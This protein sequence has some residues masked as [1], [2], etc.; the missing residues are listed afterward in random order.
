MKKII[1][2]NFRK[3]LWLG[4]IILLLL[5]IQAQLWGTGSAEEKFIFVSKMS[6]LAGL[7]G[8]YLY[9]LIKERDNST[10]AHYYY[11]LIAS[12]VALLA[13]FLGGGLALVL[14]WIFGG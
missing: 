14:H 10:E 4:S 5:A 2:I 9:L 1:T 7:V 3:A 12:V 6:A 11:L 8:S 13:G